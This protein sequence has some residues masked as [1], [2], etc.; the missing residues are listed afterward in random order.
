MIGSTLRSMVGVVVQLDEEDAVQVTAVAVVFPPDTESLSVVVPAGRTMPF[1]WASG[2]RLA[3]S[4]GSGT[5][6][7][8]AMDLPWITPV[9]HAAV[10]G[11]VEPPLFTTQTLVVFAWLS[12]RSWLPRPND[13]LVP[14]CT[15]NWSCVYIGPLTLSL[16]P[17]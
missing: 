15:R 7:A 11:C 3:L 14:D 8:L 2:N 6:G 12:T 9:G 5:S 17:Q 10:A 16:V 1:F 13:G 4:A